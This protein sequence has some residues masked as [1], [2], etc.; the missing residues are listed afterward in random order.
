MKRAAVPVLTS[1][2]LAAG[3]FSLAGCAA[4]QHQVIDAGEACS[5][6][7]SDEKATY[8]WGTDV[9]S[10]TV[11]SGASV[12]VR[13]DAPSVAVC[14]PVFTA[15]DG[16]GFVPE[17]LTD[18]TVRD[19]EAVVSLEDGLWALCVDEGDAARARLVHVDSANSESA[20]FEL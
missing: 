17:K 18:A 14:R 20:V 16:S 5:S 1:F 4:G 13:T 6:C 9:P 19:G 11:E 7:H 2:A 8:E 3:L 12:T 10:S 15:Q